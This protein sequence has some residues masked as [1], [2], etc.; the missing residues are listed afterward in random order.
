MTDWFV[1]QVKTRMEDRAAWHLRN[2]GFEVYL[3]K[4]LKQIRHARQTTKQLRPLFPGYVFVRPSDEGTRWRSINGT[5]GV[6]ALINNGG[7]PSYLSEEFVSELRAQE[8]ESGGIA[9]KEKGFAKGDS[10]LINDGAFADYC[11]VLEEVCDES[12]VILLL[13][14]MGREVRVHIATESLSIAS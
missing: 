2:Q 8:D 10:V 3:P 7:E 14:L 12:R 9:L 13:K 11:G 4:Y 1:A 5:V 6:I